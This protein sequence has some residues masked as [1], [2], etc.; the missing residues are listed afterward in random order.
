MTMMTCDGDDDDD[1]LRFEQFSTPFRRLQMISL[2]VV[3]FHN[4]IH[5]AL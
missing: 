4:A 5:Y 2:I 1:Y 3:N